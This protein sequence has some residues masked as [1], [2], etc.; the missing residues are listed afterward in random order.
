MRS[1]NW[2]LIVGT[3]K[4]P[5]YVPT[6]I[7]RNY[8]CILVLPHCT[9]EQQQVTSGLLSKGW[10]ESSSEKQARCPRVNWNKGGLTVFCSVCPQQESIF[11]IWQGNSCATDLF[12]PHAAC[13]NGFCSDP[14]GLG[15]L[16]L[17]VLCE[18]FVCRCRTSVQT[19]YVIQLCVME[20]KVQLWT[21]RLLSAAD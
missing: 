17:S 9:Q 12:K 15:S 6:V 5:S 10:S 2:F 1:M 21:A 18:A 7:S 4:T 8:L 19:V 20:A 14:R 3:L 13:M 16:C 11:L